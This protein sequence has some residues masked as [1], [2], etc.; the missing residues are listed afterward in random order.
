[1]E[2]VRGWSFSS[3]LLASHSELPSLPPSIQQ[4]IVIR[5]TEGAWTLVSFRG[6]FTLHC[7]PTRSFISFTLAFLKLEACGDTYGG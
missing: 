3:F 6:N 5:G 4:L 2:R 1:M 7:N